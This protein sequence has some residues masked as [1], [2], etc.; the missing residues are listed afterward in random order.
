LSFL[1][2]KG[3]FGSQKAR[4]PGGDVPGRWRRGP[5][6]PYTFRR[7]MMEKGQTMAKNSTMTSQG[8]GARQFGSRRW[9]PNHIPG[10]LGG[11]GGNGWGKHTQPNCDA[12]R[13]RGAFFPCTCRGP[14][15]LHRGGGTGPRAKSRPPG[16]P[17]QPH[18]Q[19]RGGPRGK[20]PL[21]KAKRVTEG[22]G[23]N[24]RKQS[25][26]GSFLKEAR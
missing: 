10:P 26:T 21:G 8:R 16:R 18:P 1:D 13:G 15:G 24:H 22:I 7:V 23:K 2:W 19:T 12:F 17:P 4:V 25:K 3:Y 11:G 9:W 14:G 5:A 20:K 6:G